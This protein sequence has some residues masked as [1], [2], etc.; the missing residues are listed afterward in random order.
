MD[1][2]VDGSLVVSVLTVVG[3]G[4]G[5]VS[6]LYAIPTLRR[7]AADTRKVETET[8]AVRVDAAGEVSAA[9]LA[10]MQ[11]ALQRATHAETDAAAVRVEMAEVRRESESTR[12][13]CDA[14]L[15]AME[16]A[17]ARYRET[18]QDHVVWDV[19]RIADLTRLGVARDDIPHAPPLLPRGAAN[20]GS[21]P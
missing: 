14:R 15:Q 20:R 16:D 21:K 6:A 1:W 10:Q 7:L 17:M 12:R 2:S 19:Q 3:G 4:G 9:A 11:A 13:D 8:D 5:L 18:A